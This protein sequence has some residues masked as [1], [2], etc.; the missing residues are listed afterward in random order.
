MDL[1]SKLEG[2]DWNRGNVKKN[3]IKHKVNAKEAEEVFFN[4]P[5]LVNFDQEHS[6]K[7]KRFRVLGRTNKKRRLFISFTLRKKKIR[8]ISARD[9]SKK[10]RINYEKV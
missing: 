6:K 2:F 10:E 5:L 8:I 1:L 3:W 9:M 4:K 7:E